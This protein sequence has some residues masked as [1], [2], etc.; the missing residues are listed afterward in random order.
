MITRSVKLPKELDARLRR[1]ARARRI[2]VSEATRQALRES[3]REDGGVN[4]LE[5]LK[6]FAGCVEGPPDLSTNKA[7]FDDYGLDAKE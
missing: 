6:K 3:L 5:A 7:Y 4:M 2:T 1:W